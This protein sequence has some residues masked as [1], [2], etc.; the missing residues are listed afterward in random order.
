[1]SKKCSGAENRKRRKEKES[2]ELIELKKT[3]KLSCYFSKTSESL[4][5]Q[6]FSGDNEEV[7]QT[8]TSAT[9]LVPTIPITSSECECVVVQRPSGTVEIANEKVECGQIG[10]K[11]DDKEI[12]S[13]DRGNFKEILTSEQKR[14]II[15][16]GPYQ[17]KGPF[18]KD[19][20]GTNKNRGFD[21]KWYFQK[22]K[23]NQLKV[24]RSWLCYSKVLNVC[25]CQPCWLFDMSCSEV[26]LNKGTSDWAHLGRNITNHEQSHSHAISSEIYFRWQMGLT[27]DCENIDEIKRAT[28]YWRK[29]L[30]RVVDVIITLATNDL[31]LREHRVSVDDT[32]SKGNFLEIIHMLAR[33]DKVL[34]DLI[35]QPKRSVNYL[36][37]QIQNELINLIANEIRKQIKD[38]IQTSPFVT[39]IFDTTQDIAK[40]DQL[41]IVFRY[42]TIKTDDEEKPV[43][44]VIEEAFCG[45]A[46]VESQKSEYLE[47]TVL[48]IIEEF[49]DV[50]KVRGQGYDGAANMSGVYSGLQARIKEKNPSAKYV[51]CCAHALNLVVNDCVTSIPE[52]RNFF[53]NV[54]NL[55]V[56][57]KA[58]SRWTLLRKSAMLEKTLKKVCPTRWSSRNQAIDALRNGYFD[59]MKILTLLSL[60]GKDREEMDQAKSLLKYFEQYPTIILILIESDVLESIDIISKKLQSVEEDIEHA[61]KMLSNLKTKISKF[62]NGWQTVKNNATNL[63]LKWNVPPHF[64][65]SRIRRKKRM[66]DEVQIDDPIINEEKRFQIEVFNRS[67]DIISTQITERFVAV[68]EICSTFKC[69]RP[70]FLKDSNDEQILEHCKV[71]VENYPDDLS[72]SL[73]PQTVRFKTCF[74]S[75]IEEMKSVRDLADTIIVRAQISSSFP[76]LVNACLIFL[77]IPVTTASAERSFSKLKIIKNYLR[78]T[79]SQERL[80]S[81]S[82][83]SIE[84]A[85]A[86]N[87]DLD[88]AI[89]QFASAK[90]RKKLH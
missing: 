60:D 87:I 44:L 6:Q 78:T 55:Y 58:I 75:H 54:Q 51:H 90:S 46:E 88:D 28:D 1:M 62:R 19:Q 37:P 10:E 71:L 83:I 16:L 15:K 82:T 72:Y 68:S 38:E 43:N 34:A 8:E 86:R 17:P 79:M 64:P 2:S 21:E 20:D 57:F 18:P 48:S 81:L 49:S 3:R 26:G 84:R 63:C 69:L 29:V 7:T 14:L 9:A 22:N 52:I 89:T 67:L 66:F 24:K 25:Y 77:T 27:V 13:C 12:I 23:N 76:D 53:D 31:P 56:F 74:L 70:S 45:F 61:S 11:R 35:K 4:N 36:S 47:K 73:G 59:I 33:Y 50:S 85:R 30:K 5:K 41:S 32:V 42:V 40:I 39:L 80:S 65:A